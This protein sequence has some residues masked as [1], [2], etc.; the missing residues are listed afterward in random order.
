MS[1]LSSVVQ[2]GAYSAMPAAGVTGR[3]YFATDS[4]S[5]G[6]WYRD[7]GT[8]WDQCTPP[9]FSIDGVTVSGTPSSGQVLTATS[10]S[11]ADWQ[12]PSGGGGGGSGDP[13]LSI[14][15]PGSGGSPPTFSWRNQGGAT[16]TVGANS[17]YL[18]APAGSGNNVRGREIACPSTPY[19]ISIGIVPVT[20]YNYNT[21]GL[22]VTDGTKL[23]CLALTTPSNGYLNVDEY[24]SVSSFGA[25]LVNPQ[26]MPITPTFLKVVDDGTN[27]TWKYSPDGSNW[28]QIY[29]ASR[30]AYLSSPTDV[31]FF[32]ES[33]S[34]SYPCG[35]LLVSW[36]Q[37]TS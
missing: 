14:T 19:S 31:G 26:C 4:T 17:R 6:G 9:I 27:L 18:L 13:W 36:A 16:E 29:Q 11:A 33:N 21:C 2:R 32:A 15:N 35:I 12:T 24:A 23:V 34:S 25:N 37:G 8:T 7:N 22:Y 5:S 30:T 10:A 1:T 28:V 20:F 3:L